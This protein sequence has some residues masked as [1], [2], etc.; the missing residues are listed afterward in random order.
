MPLS[1]LLIEQKPPESSRTTLISKDYL[2]KRIPRT[3]DH[4]LC[5]AVVGH[6]H[7]VR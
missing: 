7:E 3:L 2:I 6:R 5:T 1:D 4:D